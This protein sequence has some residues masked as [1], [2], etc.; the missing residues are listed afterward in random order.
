MGVEY[1]GLICVGYDYDQVEALYEECLDDSGDLKYENLYE[2]CEGEGLESFSPYYDAD[3]ED[4]IYGSSIVAS[5]DYSYKELDMELDSS[6]AHELRDLY[7]R[8]TMT[9]KAYLMAQGW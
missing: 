4:C 2:F 6:I 5:N 8:F 9:P 7:E 3:R 1:R